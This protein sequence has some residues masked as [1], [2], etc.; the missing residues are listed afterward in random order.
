MGQKAEESP[1][2]GCPGSFCVDNLWIWKAKQL[3]CIPAV[4]IVVVY[5][6]IAF[7]GL[8]QN[9]HWIISKCLLS[10]CILSSSHCGNVNEAMLSL[11]PLEK[12][13]FLVV[14]SSPPPAL[15]CSCFVQS[16]GL[17]TLYSLPVWFSFFSCC[18][19]LL[20]IRESPVP[21]ITWSQTVHLAKA[22]SN[23]GTSA[24]AFV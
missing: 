20:C 15:V 5:L 4:L 23:C 13:S 7:L 12:T 3:S 2:S 14:S 11:V 16:P 22:I 10:P 9:D 19:V 1:C 24:G 8:L 17:H 18:I 21:V 6:G